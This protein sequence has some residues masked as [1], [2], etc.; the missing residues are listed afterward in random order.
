MT[1]SADAR[2]LRRIEAMGIRG[3][4]RFWGLMPPE[5]AMRLRPRTA[6]V[7]D[8]LLTLAA[9]SDALRMNRVVGLG[10][11]GLAEEAMIDRIIDVYRG[12]KLR[13]FSV[14]VSPGPQAEPISRWL[15]ARGLTRRGGHSLLVRAGRLAIPPVRSGVRVVRARREHAEAILAIHERCFAVPASRRSWSLAGLASAHHEQYVALVGSTPVAAGAL[16]VDRGLAW[17]GGGATLTRWRRHGA[18]AAL[19]A[20]RLRRAARRGC[21]WVWVETAAPAP[22]RPAGSRRNLLRFGFEEVCV[23]PIFVWHRR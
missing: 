1:R 11:D 14:V 5:V 16:Q 18:H 6:R 19:I 22:G 2:L 3:T 8:A 23:K 9:D 17:I 4:E 7:G 13:R 20:A 12:A 21:P 15:L 10:H